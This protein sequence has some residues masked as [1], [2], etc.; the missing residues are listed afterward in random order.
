[1]CVTVP[2]MYIGMH[3]NQAVVPYSLP[4]AGEHN[5]IILHTVNAGLV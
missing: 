4:Q 3:M 2:G 1:M 5:Y